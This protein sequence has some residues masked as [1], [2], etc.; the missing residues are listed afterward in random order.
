MSNYTKQTLL[1]LSSTKKILPDLIHL[2][3]RWLELLYNKFKE[4]L[5]LNP[6]DSMIQVELGILFKQT[7]SN[8]ISESKKSSKQLLWSQ[9][10][11]DNLINIF[12]LLC[13]VLLEFISIKLKLSSVISTTSNSSIYET[14]KDVIT[15]ILSTFNCSKQDLECFSTYC[16]IQ[17]ICQIIHL[18]TE[19]PVVKKVAKKRKKI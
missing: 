18:S 9:L 11:F 1:T 4:I 16:N 19:Q 10:I 17:P 7:T 13:Q 3:F 15:D 2:Q 14:G 8:I 6:H 5:R 12:H